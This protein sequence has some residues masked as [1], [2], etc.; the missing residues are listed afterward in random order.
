M[1]YTQIQQ[2]LVLSKTMNMTK[3]AKE[4]Y[5][6][7]QKLKVKHF[8]LLLFLSNAAGKVLFR[9]QQRRLKPAEQ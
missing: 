3:A 1:N 8:P 7:F 6:P 4:L 5:I 9:Q 2:F